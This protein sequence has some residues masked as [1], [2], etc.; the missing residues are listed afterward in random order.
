M[1]EQA[2]P[3]RIFELNAAEIAAVNALDPIML[4]HALIEEGVVGAQEIDDA[5]ILPHLTFDQELGFLRHRLAQ[6]FVERHKGR[7]IRRYPCDIAQEQ[8]LA[9]EVLDQG[10]RARIGHHALDLRL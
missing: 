1:S 2:E 5:M 9:D 8:P 10:L 7:R 4:G 3:L 6:I